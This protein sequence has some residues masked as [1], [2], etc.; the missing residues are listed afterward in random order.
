MNPSTL[1]TFAHDLATYSLP[2]IT[3]ALE[4]IGKTP[5]NQGETAFPDVATVLEVLRGVVR[6]RKAAESNPGKK[7]SDEVDEFWKQPAVPLDEELQAKVD[8]LNEKFGMKKKKEIDTTPV[9]MTCPHCSASL[10]V[11]PNIRFWTADELRTYADA[12][13]S[14]HAMAMEN[15]TA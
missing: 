6:S 5:R 4:T 3:T 9:E 2:D 13:D 8:A 7:W 1:V 14:L 15:V 10:P 12:L 11:A